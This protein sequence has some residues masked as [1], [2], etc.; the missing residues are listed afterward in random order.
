MP[1]RGSYVLSGQNSTVADDL[2]RFP[3]SSYTY[4]PYSSPL[5][6]ASEVAAIPFQGLAGLSGQCFCE[7][8]LSQHQSS[9]AMHERGSELHFQAG[10][11]IIFEN[12]SSSMYKIYVGLCWRVKASS[13]KFLAIG[14]A[15]D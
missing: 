14:S 5:S 11:Q 10:I 2:S 13:I 9:V 15:S 8:Y 12:H 4:R 1:G 7:G 6:P 3:I